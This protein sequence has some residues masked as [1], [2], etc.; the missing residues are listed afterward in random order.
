MCLEETQQTSM[1][2][3]V[4]TYTSLIPIIELGICVRSWN[5]VDQNYSDK[6]FLCHLG[7]TPQGQV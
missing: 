3:R 7:P 2:V 1:E 6:T 4:E 5:F